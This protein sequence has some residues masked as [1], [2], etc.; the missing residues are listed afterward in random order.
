MIEAAKTLSN[1]APWL[2]IADVLPY[3]YRCTISNCKHNVEVNSGIVNC[4]MDSIQVSPEGECSEFE[5]KGTEGD[6]T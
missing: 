2:L 3:R 6:N 4:N 1:I 5:A